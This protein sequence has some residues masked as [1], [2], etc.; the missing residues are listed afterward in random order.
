[1]TGLSPLTRGNLDPGR[2]DQETRGPIP[3]H[4]GEPVGLIREAARLGAYPRSRG[5]TTPRPAR[6]FAARGLSPLTRGNLWD[7]SKC[8]RSGGPIPAHA[9]EPR[10]LVTSSKTTGAYPRSR[11]GTRSAEYKTQRDDGLSPLTR[12]NH[13][14]SARKPSPGGPIPAHAGE[15]LVSNS[16]KRKRKH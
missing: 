1:M 2:E 3:A 10:P 6:P 9:G 5:G 12:G 16:L 8:W 13:F 7:E 11:G 4:A 14:P 15:P